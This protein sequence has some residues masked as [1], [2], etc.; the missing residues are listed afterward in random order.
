MKKA[1][2]AGAASAVLAA[3]P[4]VGAF[5]ATSVYDTINVTVT[6]ECTFNRTAGEGTYS[7]TMLSGALNENFGSSTFTATCNFED[8]TQP[9][10]TGA[11]IQVTA[12]FVS[13]MSGSNEIPYSASALTAGT[14]GWN[15]AKGDRMADAVVMTNND[16]LID[17]TGVF[18]NQSAT[19]WYSVATANNQAAGTYTGYATYTLAEN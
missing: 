18:A 15:A 10:A 14:A 1:V 5:A 12:S 16:N 13:L 17:A 4:I 2:I 9:G 7:T 3:M 19:V 6:D 8:P 11:D